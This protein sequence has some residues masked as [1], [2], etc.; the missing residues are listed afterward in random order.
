MTMKTAACAMAVALLAALQSLFLPLE[1]NRFRLKR[2]P[3]WHFD[4]AGKKQI[5]RSVRALRCGIVPSLLLEGDCNITLQLEGD[6]NVGQFDK[7]AG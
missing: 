6:R 3:L 5:V 4:G 2:L 7:A 1:R